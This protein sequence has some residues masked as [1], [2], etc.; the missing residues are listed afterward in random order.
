MKEKD[1]IRKGTGHLTRRGFLGMGGMAI[2]GA[3]LPSAVWGASTQGEN[4][5]PEKPRIRETRVLGRTGF[6]V[7]DIGMGCAPVKESNLVRYA[8]DRGVNYFDTSELYGNGLSETSIGK[9]LPFMDRQK[10]FVT[11]KLG[12][13]K[14]ETEKDL[15][16]RFGKC[17][18][19]LNTS[20]VD[21]L[22]IAGAT[23]SA[24]IQQ[25]AFHGAVKRLKADGRLKYA[26]VACH[27]PR[28]MDGDPME[29]VLLAAVEDGRFDIMLLTYNFLN[30][31]EG[32]KVLNACKG[33]NVGTTA[34]KTAPGKIKEIPDFDPVNPSEA[35]ENQIKMM[36]SFGLNRQQAV[37]MVAQ[38]VQ[39]DKVA[40]KQTKPFLEEYGLRTEEQLWEASVKWVRQNPDMH[41]VCVSMADFDKVD[42]AVA[43]SGKDLTGR[44]QAFLHD[45]E[46]SFG[47]SYCR[48]G[49]TSCSGPCRSGLAVS[50]IMR[51]A[52]YY[53]QGYEKLAMEK[54]ASLESDNAI[55][56]AGCDAPCEGSCPHGV[57]V[58]SNLFNAH[59][60]LTLA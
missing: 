44:Q 28:G 55:A 48:H 59:R 47:W 26:G 8:Y 36:M 38:M 53:E 31:E 35:Y 46:A 24:Q 5:E 17:Q 29:K 58:R 33:K 15:I 18:E 14:D 57:M 54:Y 19:R 3:S 22:L 1:Q 41:S 39:A 43:L 32:E 7:S 30:S 11:T 52:Y 13:K 21:A 56:C 27:G 12:L 45:Y 42:K 4:G 51:Y 37:H 49:C 2:A 10:V 50:T 25:K 16:D 60:M 9:A 34:M 20:Y 23:T 40:R 6:A